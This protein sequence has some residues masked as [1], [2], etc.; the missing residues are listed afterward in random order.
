MDQKTPQNEFVERILMMTVD[1]TI[2]FPRETA[3]K[4]PGPMLAITVLLH[5]VCDN[6]VEKF[7]EAIRLIELFVTKALVEVHQ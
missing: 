1:P 5:R 7:D 3:G 2:M 6:D 4:P